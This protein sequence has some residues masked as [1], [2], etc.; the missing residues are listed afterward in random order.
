MAVGEQ[1]LERAGLSLITL[2]I[3]KVAYIKAQLKGGKSKADLHASE[4]QVRDVCERWLNVQNLH[5]ALQYLQP[6]SNRPGAER[7]ST[8]RVSQLEVLCLM[9]Y[10]TQ[11]S[12]TTS[13]LA[14]C[15][16]WPWTR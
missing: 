9:L 10:L 13:T 14:A 4:K 11:C 8:E 7:A 15:L 3:S 1:K 5:N 2:M 12:G 16:K 6:T